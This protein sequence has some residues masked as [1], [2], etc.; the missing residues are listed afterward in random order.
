MESPSTDGSNNVE[1][2]G[3][4]IDSSDASSSAPSS[5]VS[6]SWALH[7]FDADSGINQKFVQ[8][9][10]LWVE[11]VNEH[12]GGVAKYV[13]QTLSQDETFRRNYCKWLWETF[14]ED[15]STLY[16]HSDDIPRVQSRDD[17]SFTPPGIVHVCT[18][19]YEESCTLKPFPAQLTCR[20]LVHQY[21]IDGF[22]TLGEPLLITQP[23]EIKEKS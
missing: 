6:D 16:Q 3:N 19:G 13:R 8:V 5:W 17:L 11:H 18:L 15:E 23:L 14:P 12:L 20:E 10:R 2:V 4:A 21:M 9:M 1:I 22:N 7:E